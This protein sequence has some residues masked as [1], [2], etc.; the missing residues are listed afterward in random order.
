MQTRFRLLVAFACLVSL[1]SGNFHNPQ[2]IAATT[3]DPSDSP[4]RI[5]SSPQTASNPPSGYE[6]ALD[7][8]RPVVPIWNRPLEDPVG[9]TLNAAGTRA[10]VDPLRAASCR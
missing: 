6:G 4:N 10:F 5:L 7:D 9:L 8:L 1:L 2:P 3:R